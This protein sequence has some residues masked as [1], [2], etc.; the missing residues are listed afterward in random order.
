MVIGK[1]AL[2]DD[3]GL[4]RSS[5]VELRRHCS[6]VQIEQTPVPVPTNL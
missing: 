3:R 5:E 1:A 6:T 2:W 4:G